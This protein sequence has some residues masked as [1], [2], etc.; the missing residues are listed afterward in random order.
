MLIVS[1]SVVYRWSWSK[2]RFLFIAKVNV[3]NWKEKYTSIHRGI[4]SIILQR[5]IRVYSRLY[6]IDRERQAIL[7]IEFYLIMTRSIMA[8]AILDKVAIYVAMQLLTVILVFN[9]PTFICVRFLSWAICS[10]VYKVVVS[11]DCQN[12]NHVW[13]NNFLK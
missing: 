4:Q 5:D 7:S 11:I 8:W 10:Q 6:C 12:I 2:G 13:N 1:Y 3:A 9:P